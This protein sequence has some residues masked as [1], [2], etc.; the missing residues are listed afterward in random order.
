M[1]WQKKGQI[2]APDQSEE[3]L[4]YYGICP[5]PLVLEDRIRIYFGA[6]NADK[7]GAIYFIDTKKDDPGI[8]LT[9]KPVLAFLPGPAGTFDD[10]GSMPSSIITIN[11]EHYLLYTGYE[12]TVKVPYL[13]LTGIA[14]I[15]ADGTLERIQNVPLL[16]RNESELTIRSAPTILQDSDGY[17]M[18]YVSAGMWEWMDTPLFKNKLM[19]VYSVNHAVSSDGLHWTV[20]AKAVLKYQNEEEFGFGRP[21][22][23]KENNIYK[24][25][26]SVRSR[27]SPY[28]IGYAESV[29]G[30]N[31]KRKDENVSIHTSVDGWDS[32]MICY[33]AVVEASGKNYMFYNGNNNGITG[34]GYAEL[35]SE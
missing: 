33:A 13:L 34:F 15:K 18:W 10:C 24:L 20:K 5:T 19:P 3:Y 28:K 6:T 9:A 8:K 30:I 17:K 11:N 25:F 7:I 12:R 32:E 2:F 27:T 21:W 29:D 35:I 16:E 14:K 26:Y 1:K 23:L 4:H 31:W 22:I